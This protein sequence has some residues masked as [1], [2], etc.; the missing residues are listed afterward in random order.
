MYFLYVALGPYLIVTPLRR[1]NCLIDVETQFVSVWDHDYKGE[2]VRLREISGSV[3]ACTHNCEFLL[4]GKCAT[5]GVV[6]QLRPCFRD[7]CTDATSDL[8]FSTMLPR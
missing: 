1:G 7:R 8:I 2:G 6:R 4:C 3:S 5:M